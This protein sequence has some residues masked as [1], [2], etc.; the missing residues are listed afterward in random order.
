MASTAASFLGLFFLIAVIAGLWVGVLGLRQ[1]GRNGVWWTMMLAISGITLGA[2]GIVGFPVL[3]S[4]PLG[5]SGESIAILG[6]CSAIITFGM[7]LFVIG[8]AIHGLKAA[9][10]NERVRELEQLT[11]AMG[12]EINRMRE[13]R[14]S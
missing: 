13:G 12:E 7:L 4:T 14:L 10:V 2:L 9:R 8:F 1:S 6:I 11:E 5:A 3:S